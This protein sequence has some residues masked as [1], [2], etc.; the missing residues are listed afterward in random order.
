M[1]ASRSND[2][3]LRPLKVIRDDEPPE[4]RLTRLARPR[5]ACFEAKVQRS[6]FDLLLAL[7]QENSVHPLRS[8]SNR[9]GKI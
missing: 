9:A 5:A 8:S 1:C 4:C 7:L 6:G 2:S 3:K